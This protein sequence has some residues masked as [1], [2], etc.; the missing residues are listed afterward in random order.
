MLLF[1][2]QHPINFLFNKTWALR[3]F[4]LL[5]FTVVL[6]F[7]VFVLQRKPQDRRTQALE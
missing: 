5:S 7:L 6:F 3:F 1:C 2:L 4:L